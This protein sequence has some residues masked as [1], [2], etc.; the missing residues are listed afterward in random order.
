[1]KSGKKEGRREGGGGR[2]GLIKFNNTPEIIKLSNITFLFTQQC[3]HRN[4]ERRREED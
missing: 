3:Q 1:M 4:L 2:N